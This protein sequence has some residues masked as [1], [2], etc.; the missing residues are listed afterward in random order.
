MYTVHIGIQGY[1]TLEGYR[2]TCNKLIYT[3]IKICINVYVNII[4]QYTN[5]HAHFH[6]FVMLPFFIIC[7]LEEVKPGGK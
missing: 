4:Y 2:P 1:K 5:K 6:V 7:S 3:Y